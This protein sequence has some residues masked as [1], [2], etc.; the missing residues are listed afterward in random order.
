[1][2]SQKYP[3]PDR[4]F[5]LGSSSLTEAITPL[6]VPV[7]VGMDPVG[8]WAFTVTGVEST[9]LAVRIIAAIRIRPDHLK[10]FKFIESPLVSVLKKV[11]VIIIH[12]CPR[13]FTM[14][15]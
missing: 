5:T 9:K 6:G 3:G 1:M 12:L 11:I 7:T 13:E 2:G 14:V 15:I 10:S 8:C 4:T